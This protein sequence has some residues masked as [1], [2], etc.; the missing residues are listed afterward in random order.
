[1]SLINFISSATPGSFPEAGL[2]WLN[3]NIHDILITLFEVIN[4]FYK[5]KRSGFPIGQ[6]TRLRTLKPKV[7]G[8]N[9][10]LQR[11]YYG[12]YY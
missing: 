4:L 9:L 7:N 6:L 12:G 10:K 2:K 1:M 11:L 5:E 3:H 8:L